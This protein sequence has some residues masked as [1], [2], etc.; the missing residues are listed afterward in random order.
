MYN[1]YMYNSQRT[2][3]AHIL[4]FKEDKIVKKV[5]DN[6]LVGRA[7]WDRPMKKWVTYIQVLYLFKYKKEEEEKSDLLTEH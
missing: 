6:V 1:N 3:D 7:S 4:R 2:R 5:R